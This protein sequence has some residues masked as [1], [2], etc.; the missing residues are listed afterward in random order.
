MPII[1]SGFG[2]NG[3]SDMSK[4]TTT[5]KGLVAASTDTDAVTYLLFMFSFLLLAWQLTRHLPGRPSSG[6]CFGMSQ[7]F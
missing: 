5:K 7:T 3:F 1:F 6:F 4:H 2:T